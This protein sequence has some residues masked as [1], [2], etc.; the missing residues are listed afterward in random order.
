MERAARIHGHGANL[1]DASVPFPTGFD[2]IWMSQF[3]D[4]FSEAE[5]TA[6]LTRAARSMTADSRLYIMETFWDRQKFETAAYCLT[7]ISIYFTALAN[8][9]SKMYHS[10]DMERCIHAAGLTVEEIY[11][12]LGMGHSILQ[13]RL[14]ETT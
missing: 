14:R 9:N 10:D 13:C 7:Q 3:L 6:I 12:H 11:D 2:A 1:L 4:C 5:V 8:G